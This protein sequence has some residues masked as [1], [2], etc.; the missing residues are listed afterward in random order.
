MTTLDQALSKLQY[1]KKQKAFAW[2]KF[3]EEVND[4]HRHDH[5]NY[6]TFNRVADDK[7]IPTHIKDEMKAMAIALKKKW[8]CPCCMDMIA[9]DALV[10][11]NCGHYYCKLCLEGWKKAS[12]D[13]GDSKWKCGM[14]NRSHGYGDD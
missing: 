13:R 6:D 7:A 3:Y 14:C 12:K 10:I 2:A 4:R 11:T 9:D 1:A 8:E 5:V